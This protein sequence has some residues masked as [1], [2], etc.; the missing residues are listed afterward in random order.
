MA[1]V[2]S[3]DRAFAIL[4]ALAVQPAGI[5]ELAARVE[6]PKSTVARLLGALEEVRAVE[7]PE[8][9]GVYQLG[10]GI[11]DIA[12]GSQPHRNLVSTARPFLIDL[13]ERTGEA[14]GL[15]TM[16]DGWVYFL[17][18]VASERD[19]QVR[20]WTG[21]YGLAHTVP[22]GMAMLAHA[23][24]AVVDAYLAQSLEALTPNTITHEA[25]FRDRLDQVRSAGYA[26]GFE[27][28]AMGINSVAAP[29]FGPAGI[30]AAIH[31]H[32]PA[33]RF[34][35]PDRTHDLG[36]LLVELAAILS[37]QLKEYAD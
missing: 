26:W 15:D 5:T 18:Q 31:V 29:V 35:D 17:D 7:Q 22:A 1:G 23:D 37:A 3:I 36:L 34:P 16:D 27:E 2:Q 12:G 28:F 14:S 20:D 8:A 9:G 33:Y 32:G 11:D 10:S 24:A 19:V 25:E 6:L 21:E 13:T 30:E 4:R